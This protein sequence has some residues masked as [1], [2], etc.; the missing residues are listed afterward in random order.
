[1]DA[2]NE[3]RFR[4]AFANGHHYRMKARKLREQASMY[5][6]GD[7]ARAEC[8]KAALRWE[9]RA[10]MTRRRARMVASR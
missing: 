2:A 1:M 9:H 10:E 8:L 5:R 6:P 4:N 3:Y 7:E